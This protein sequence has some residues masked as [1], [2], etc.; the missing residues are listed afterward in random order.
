M[1]ENM[2]KR[3]WNAAATKCRKNQEY[4]VAKNVKSNENK[5][6]ASHHELKHESFNVHAHTN[7]NDLMPASM[8]HKIY[9]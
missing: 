9:F 7:Y 1:N 6:S 2:E 8:F 5:T 3:D 4:E